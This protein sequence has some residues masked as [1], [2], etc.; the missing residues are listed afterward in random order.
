MIAS[1]NVSAMLDHADPAD[2]AAVYTDLGLTL[3]YKPSER[4]VLAETR[5]VYE[6][7]VGGGT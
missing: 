3:T 6:A 4:L 1:V 5:P 2:K 7:R